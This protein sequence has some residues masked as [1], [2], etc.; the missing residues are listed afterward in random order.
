LLREVFAVPPFGAVYTRTRIIPEWILHL[1]GR[2]REIQQMPETQIESD[3]VAK[4]W[5]WKLISV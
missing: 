2:L 4:Q 5:S 1:C 3:T